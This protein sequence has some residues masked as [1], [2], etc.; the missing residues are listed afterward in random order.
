MGIT[1]Y[2]DSSSS[3]HAYLDASWLVIKNKDDCISTTGYIVYLGRNPVSWTS[4]KQKTRARSLTKAD[5]RATTSLLILLSYYGLQI[6]FR[7]L[8]KVCL[9][10]QLFIAIMQEPLMYVPTLCFTLK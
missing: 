3:L 4:R 8:D 5:N 2:A 7:N 1:I 10:N 6:N 9:T